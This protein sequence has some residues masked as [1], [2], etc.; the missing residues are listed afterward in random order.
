MYGTALLLTLA[1]TDQ[2]QNFPADY[3]TRCAELGYASRP[4]TAGLPAHYPSH[5]LII[6][7]L[8]RS[9]KQ[10]NPPGSSV[11]TPRASRTTPSISR[12]WYSHLLVQLYHL[13]LPN[14]EGVERPRPRLP[15]RPTFSGVLQNHLVMLIRRYVVSG[16][17]FPCHASPPAACHQ[18]S[19]RQRIQVNAHHRL[20]QIPRHLRQDLRVL[21]VSRRAHNC[22]CPLQRVARLEYAGTN[23]DALRAQA[24]HQSRI[25]R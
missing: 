9:P 25:G 5:A 19:L 17:T 1:Q 14:V 8:H 4:V 2:L 24:H 10:E 15:A 3:Q 7:V 11:A 12:W 23:K 6:S 22:L 18:F 21:V 13:F 16:C 20:T